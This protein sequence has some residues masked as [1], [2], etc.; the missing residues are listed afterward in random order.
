MIRENVSSLGYNLTKEHPATAEEYNALCPKREDACRKDAVA[1]TD[2]RSVFPVFRDTFLTELG[3]K[4]GVER[5]NSGTEDEPKWETEGKWHARIV[6][7]SG[8]S[9]EDFIAANTALAQ[10]HMDAAPFDPSEREST[11]QG[12]A[13]GKN[14]LKNA[15]ELQAR[16]VDKVNAVVT[17]LSQKL[18][19]AITLSGD[20]EADKKVIARALADFRRQKAAEQEAANKAELGL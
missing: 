5:I 17:A 16:G 8:M 7:K 6:A 4:Y 9:R 20:A 1:N 2:Y 13:I 19:R 3:T 12:P 14:D 10:S 15:T 11:G 18:N